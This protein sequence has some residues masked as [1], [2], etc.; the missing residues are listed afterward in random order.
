MC[1][2]VRT[3]C[4]IVLRLFVFECSCVV[5]VSVQSKNDFVGVVCVY[6][7]LSVVLYPDFFFIGIVPLF[8]SD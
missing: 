7:F 2:C 4:V 3:L 8:L 6:K 5:C 1:V